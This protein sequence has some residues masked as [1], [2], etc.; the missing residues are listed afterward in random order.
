MLAPPRYIE[1]IPS[2]LVSGLIN[3]GFAWPNFSQHDRIALSVDTIG[4]ADVT[5][6]GAAA[7]VTFSITFLLTCIKFF[8]YRRTALKRGE[9]D[10]GAVPFFPTGL[11]IALHYTLFAFGTFVALAVLWQRFFGSVYVTPLAATAIV[12]IVAVVTAAN[13]ETR[14]ARA[15]IERS[16]LRVGAR[17]AGGGMAA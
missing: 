2:A 14:T 12:A 8:S 1:A 16:L 11:G 9:T 6:L 13:A 15:L 7:T 4:S 17:A 3:A 5:A 10:I